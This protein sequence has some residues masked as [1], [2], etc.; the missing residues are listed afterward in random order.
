MPAISTWGAF[1]H[2]LPHFQDPSHPRIQN[3]LVSC[4]D[5]VLSAHPATAP[6]LV[7]CLAQLVRHS[8]LVRSLLPSDHA[9]FGTRLFLDSDGIECLR[10]LL[11]VEKATSPVMPVTGL[12]PHIIYLRKVEE[13]RQLLLSAPAAAD[14]LADAVG[15]KVQ[16][17]LEELGVVG[18]QVTVRV[19]TH[20]DGPTLERGAFGSRRWCRWPVFGRACR[21]RLFRRRRAAAASTHIAA[22]PHVARWANLSA[23]RGLPSSH[24]MSPRPYWLG[25]VAHRHPGCDRPSTDEDLPLL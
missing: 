23:A 11:L 15:A 25:T 4:F 18:G 7:H 1:G 8:E 5:N 2:L 20:P 14:G 16:E 21:H 13:I 6:V 9:V 19:L 12:P 3:A 24:A 10:S 17:R 22:M